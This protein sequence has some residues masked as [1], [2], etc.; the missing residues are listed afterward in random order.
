MAINTNIDPYWDDYNQ[1]TAVDGL[2]PQEK[3]NQILF[4][5]GVSIQARELTQI[6]SILQ[7]Q[8]SS[9]GDHMFTNGSMV[10]PGGV[11]VS[12][13]IAYVKI[14]LASG[15]AYDFDTLKGATITDGTRSA[16]IIHCVNESA[17]LN[18]PVTLYINYSEGSSEFASGAL[19]IGG[20]TVGTIGNNH[21][22]TDS[23][24]TGFGI[25]ASVNAGIYYIR[26]HFVVVKEDTIV[27][28]KYTADATVNRDI[29]FTVTESIVGPGEDVSLYDNSQGTVNQSAPG[30]H[31]LQIKTALTSL[32]RSVT[33]NTTGTD[34]SLLARIENGVVVSIL[35]HSTYNILSD[36][37]ARR[38][39]DESG[40]YAL[41][42]F[43]G[44]VV[45]NTATLTYEVE[46]SKGYVKGYEVVTHS[47]THVQVD[48]ARDTEIKED[49]TRQ[50]SYHNVIIV[51]GEL[52]GALPTRGDELTLKNSGGST[53]GT[54]TVASVSHFNAM[55]SAATDL[56]RIDVHNVVSSTLGGA[57]TGLATGKVSV[58]G[59]ADLTVYTGWGS[60]TPGFGFNS[61]NWVYKLPQN[62]VKTLQ[63]PTSTPAS[64]DY[65]HSYEVITQIGGTQTVSGLGVSFSTSVTGEAFV[66]STS[67]NYVVYSVTDTKAFR[68]AD[69]TVSFNSSSDTAT[70][71]FA[72]GTTTPDGNTLSGSTCKLVAPMRRTGGSS[73]GG[74]GSKVLTSKTLDVFTVNSGS[75]V[76][77]TTFNDDTRLRDTVPSTPVNYHDIIEI[78]SVQEWN[79]SGNSLIR[80]VTEYFTL[81]NGQRD[82]VYDVGRIKTKGDTNYVVINDANVALRV[83]FNYWNHTSAKDYFTVDSYPAAE[84]AKIGS[85]DGVELS[86]SIDF[87]QLIGTTTKN[88]PR[89]DS[90]FS[91]DIT[92]YLNRIDK[93]FIDEGG[94]FLVSAGTSAL[95]PSEP[96]YPAGTMLLATLYI[97]AYTFK[98]SDVY[99]KHADNKRYTMRDIGRIEERINRLDYFTSLSILE[100]QANSQ[101][102]YDSSSGSHA[103]KTGIIVDAFGDGKASH[104]AS[105]EF[106]AG[107]DR[108][109]G[110]C[111]PIFTEDNVNL[112]H[113]TSASTGTKTNA[114]ITQP[115]TSTPIVSQLQASGNININPFSVFNWT[116]SMALNPS[117]DEWKETERRPDVVIDDDSTYDALVAQLKEENAIGTVWGSWKTNW[118]GTNTVRS[119]GQP[120]AGGFRNDVWRTTKKKRT[121]TQT[122]I[123]T[124]TV[125]ENRGDRVVEVNLLPYMRSRQVEVNIT[126]CKPNVTLSV[127]FDGTDV[128]DYV[129]TSSAQATVGGVD[130]KTYAKN[131]ST[132]PHS[133]G[134]TAITTDSNGAKTFYFWVPE[135]MTAGTKDILVTEL[136]SAAPSDDITKTSA[137][138]PYT[139]KGLLESVE[140]VTA[141]TRVPTIVRRSVS[142]TKSSKRLVKTYWTDPLAQSFMVD[143]EGGCYIK[144]IDLFFNNVAPSGG[145]PVSVQIRE[146]ENGMPTQKM[147]PF[148]EAT[149]NAG[150][151]STTAATNFAFD[152]L[153]YIN[154]QV[155]Y[156]FVIMSNSNEYTVKYATVGERDE[157]DDMIQEQPYSGV[158]FKSAN[159]STWTPDQASD[160]KFVINRAKFTSSSASV[161]LDVDS[162]SI[163]GLKN[164]PIGT[165]DGSNI[166]TVYHPN[167]GLAGG[168]E[169]TIYGSDAINNIPASEINVTHTVNASPTLDTF[170]V[171]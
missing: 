133:S 121:G 69:Y 71:T 92:Y 21:D 48:K 138:A 14:E 162:V 5:P 9:L 35:E 167:H 114:L 1:A 127:F 39:Y 31:R 155:E 115:N 171:T 111:R 158:M 83:T 131:N 55:S 128:S 30:A 88:P 112:V 77:F 10:V 15:Y 25:L 19:T 129:S 90:S 96:T 153:V 149:I 62:V 141:A 61:D 28:S 102:I 169:V 3:Y 33:S 2:T 150:S 148:A 4:R 44:R 170:S 24:L 43:I 51:S 89:P 72:S 50:L 82:S 110:I 49:Q 13:N 86:D 107:I 87:R 109:N 134:P 67:N 144:S 75:N 123:K 85:Y 64:P 132:F 54:A 136:S 56:Y 147:L 41:N 164:D 76:D 29:G 104:V 65:D 36:T 101:Q 126:R 81:D 165:T 106:R 79:V 63:S 17:G 143:L 135:G 157:N 27:V 57:L 98:A 145:A 93:V 130:A 97:P 46:P 154:P 113:N 105:P 78:N 66:D 12:D 7:N 163:K 142:D 80:D 37:M 95:V 16:I 103:F 152:D 119:G 120:G 139:S 53:I 34:F 160:L 108:V 6:Q 59:G 73:T 38:T 100:S 22:A 146:M 161:T 18:D 116:G 45:D 99:I 74:H 168:D 42:P 118:T 40:N 91:S 20:T 137:V 117:S 60:E 52:D 159:N 166:I 140:N 94:N 11:T 47:K 156:C 84:Y 125:M 23:E 32:D 26:K 70:I 124:S 68:R 151:I 58:S 8:V 122:Y